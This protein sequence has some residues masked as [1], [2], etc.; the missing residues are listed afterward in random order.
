MILPFVRELLT[1]LEHCAPF[2]RVRRHLAFAAG[3]KR[4][5]GLTATARA[6]YL[7]LF[8]REAQ[9]PV[10]VIV[11]DNKAADALLLTLRAACELTGAIKQEQVLR[12]PAHDVLP[13]ENLSPHPDV[14]EQRASVLWKI[15]T[16]AASIV[17]V[18]VEA[19]S[20]RVFPAE[21][22]ANLGRVLR[23]EEEIDMDELTTH[24]ASVGYSPMDIVEM[25]GQFTRRGGIF[26]VYSPEADR[27]VRMELFGDEIESMRKFEPDSQRS[28]TAIDE[29]LLLP[30]TETP[31]SEDLLAAVHRRLSGS[32]LDA[33]D[34]PELLDRAFAAGGVSV[35]PGWE[36][37]CSVAGA[38][39]T[40]FELFPKVQ[41]LWKS[42]P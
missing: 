36:F 37:F 27:P 32:R 11:A 7:P 35:F 26:D 17:I 6:L 25:P 18:P 23:R 15:A 39:R 41:V 21:Y 40:L 9:S 34:D 14:Q 24:L 29:T 2:E 4:V 1:D 13:F 30:L 10:V 19:A 33:G 16:G 8:A 28:S 31:I 22:Y 20:M 42:R 3:R 38:D 12:L 5:S